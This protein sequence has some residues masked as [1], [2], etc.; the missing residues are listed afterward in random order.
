MRRERCTITARL[1][2]PCAR[3]RQAAWPAHVWPDGRILCGNCCPC[4]RR[5]AAPGRDAA[6]P[7]NDA[8]PA[9]EAVPAHRMPRARATGAAIAPA[10][11]AKARDTAPPVPRVS[12]A[13][14]G[15][16]RAIV[17]A[18]LRGDAARFRLPPA[19][20]HAKLAWPRCRPR[21]AAGAAT[22]PPA[23]CLPAEATTWPPRCRRKPERGPN[24][25]PAGQARTSSRRDLRQNISAPQ[26]SGGNFMTDWRF[27]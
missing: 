27:T 26:C 14:R 1:A 25:A 13:V 8:G 21:L 2:G 6:G 17:R 12:G 16:A 11:L 22:W 10:G 20:A 3:C 9:H 24:A 19:G 4:A 23:A 7:D 18:G 15:A 5:N